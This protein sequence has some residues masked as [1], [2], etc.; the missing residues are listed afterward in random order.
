M[1]S[2]RDRTGSLDGGESLIEHNRCRA[3]SAFR[4]S[5][6]FTMAHYGVGLGRRSLVYQGGILTLTILHAGIVVVFYYSLWMLSWV[7]Q[8][9]KGMRNDT[10]RSGVAAASGATQS[11]PLLHLPRPKP[12]SRSTSAASRDSSIR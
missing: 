2:D 1:F 11:S 3:M 10:R 4:C 7:A 5:A 8:C 9:M 12:E 6:I